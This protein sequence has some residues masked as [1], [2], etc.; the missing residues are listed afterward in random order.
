MLNRAFRSKNNSTTLIAGNYLLKT[1]S[2]SDLESLKKV[3]I[4][5]AGTILCINSR[6]V[7]NN[8]AVKICPH[9]RQREFKETPKN[10]HK[11]CHGQMRNFRATT[12]EILLEVPI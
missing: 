1:F 9:A 11:A 12:C 8:S 4:V 6:T 7:S 3:F 10:L 5:S 2:Q